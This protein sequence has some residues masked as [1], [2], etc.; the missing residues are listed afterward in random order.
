M[1]P[2]VWT[3]GK[4][5]WQ[6][7]YVSAITSLAIEW[8]DVLQHLVFSLREKLLFGQLDTIARAYDHISIELL[9]S[10]LGI[11]QEETIQSNDFY[12][13]FTICIY[14]LMEFTHVP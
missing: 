11:S 7:D 12:L 2:E 10:K 5:I 4:A 9:S 13:L 1:L 14:E 3:A 6:N 8:P